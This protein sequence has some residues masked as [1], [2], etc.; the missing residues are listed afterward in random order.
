MRDET[1][2]LPRRRDG[3]VL[4]SVGRL[5]A[6]AEGLPN[7]CFL[8]RVPN[9]NL[10]Q[11]Y[12]HAIATIVPS[13]GYETFGIVLIEALRWGTPVIARRIGPFPEIVN[14]S[15]GGLMFSTNAELLDAMGQLQLDTAR[16]HRMGM[17]GY[18]ACLEHWSE[19]VVIEQLLR[20]IGDLRS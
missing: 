15:Q 10:R 14:M 4:D 19:N 3:A 20:W 8:G 18:R 2:S 16:R 13:R 5:R 9:D 6:Q 17:N 1:S 11:Y 7:V 12:E